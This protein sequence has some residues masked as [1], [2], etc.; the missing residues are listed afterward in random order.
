MIKYLKVFLGALSVILL[1]SCSKGPETNNKTIGFVI[2][3][4]SNPFFVSMKNGALETVKSEGYNLVVL[5]SNND[6]AKERANVEDLITRKIKVI[7]INP[8]DSSAVAATVKYAN[9]Q[10]VSIITVDRAASGG[11]VVSHIQ[12]DNVKGGQM[13]ADYIN[14]MLKGQGEIIELEGIPGTSAAKERGTGFDNALANTNIKIVAKQTANFDR[15]QGLNVTQNL[16]QAHPDIQAIF[17]Q[18]DEMAL[19]AV[20]ALQEV[21]NNNIIVVGFDGTKEGIA[22]VKAGKMNATIAQ[23]PYLM[24][25]LGAEAAIKVLQNEAVNKYIVAPLKI[26]TKK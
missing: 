6:S 17:A 7:V 3:T 25:E 15:T 23:Q 11:E 24:G 16:L 8:T 22:A 14:T 26:I 4:L 13:A 9:K 2:S 20:R 1:F 10:G 19:G 12:S 21:H 18:N 5:D